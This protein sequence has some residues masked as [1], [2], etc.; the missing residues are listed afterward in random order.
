MFKQSNQHLLRQSGFG[1]GQIKRAFNSFQESDLADFE[2]EFVKSVILK[3]QNT[4]NPTL[5]DMLRWQPKQPVVTALVEEGYHQDYIKT[6]AKNWATQF[7]LTGRVAVNLSATFKKWFLAKHNNN[8]TVEIF[9]DRY[10]NRNPADAETKTVQMAL[11]ELL[12]EWQGRGD[13]PFATWEDLFET[14]RLS[15]ESYL[16][17]LIPLDSCY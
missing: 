17:H 16:D 6:E 8:F 10:K 9:C 5:Q 3:K 7:A 4:A 15:C 14:K 13:K 1:L 12:V 11:A 2:D